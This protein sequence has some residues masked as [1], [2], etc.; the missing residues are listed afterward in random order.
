MSQVGIQQY[1]V[2]T[3]YV[4]QCSS[5]FAV[6]EIFRFFPGE[7]W[8]FWFSLL[9]SDP[10]VMPIKAVVNPTNDDL[11]ALAL[12]QPRFYALRNARTTEF[13]GE[14]VPKKIKGRQRWVLGATGQR[15]PLEELRQ[16]RQYYAN[17]Y[18][19]KGPTYF[20]FYYPPRKSGLPKHYYTIVGD[21]NC[22]LWEDEVARMQM[23]A[24]GEMHFAEH[25]G[26]NSDGAEEEQQQ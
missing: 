5:V 12:K 13:M 17:T 1:P 25:N 14:I 19:T 15:V 23:L 16:A 11:Q 10:S 3:K 26:N 4:S 6:F 20:I 2:R 24:N 8:T 7:C 9:E 21:E 18:R 22:A